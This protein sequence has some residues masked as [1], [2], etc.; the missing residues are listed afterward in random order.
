MRISVS[1]SRAALVSFRASSSSRSVVHRPSFGSG[2]TSRSYARDVSPDR[3]ILRTVFRDTR[4]SRAICLIVLPLTKCSRRI[5][6]IVSTVSIPP[7]PA[8]N[9]SEQ[10]IR[11]N[12]RGSILDADNPLQGVKI[13]RRITHLADDLALGRSADEEE[14]FAR[15]CQSGKC[16]S[17]ARN[18][19][20]E[21]GFRHPN[22]PTCLLVELPMTR[23]K[24]RGMPVCTKSH[25]HHV[26]Q[27]APG[28]QPL[29][30]VKAMKLRF[31]QTRGLLYAFDVCG[32]R[33][34]VARG[35]RNMIE[36]QPAR[37]AE[38]AARVVVRDEAVVSP[39]PINMIPRNG[40]AVGPGSQQ[41]VEAL[42]GGA[43]SEADGKAAI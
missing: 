4:R 3:S 39:E 36:Q 1:C 7:P 15:R 13:A 42:R 18:E 25:Q 26:E 38:I 8:S 20:F 30:A 11:S 41:L 9:Q 21:A 29:C 37:H 12:W 5:R 28:Q 24:R 6:P 34:N 32:Y 19:G 33:V 35:R 22:N 14:H 31:I 27:R 2:W 16:Q 17:H 23:E 43:A 40:V 10:R